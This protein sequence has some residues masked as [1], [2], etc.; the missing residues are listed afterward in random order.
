MLSGSVMP[1]LA[2]LALCSVCMMYLGQWRAQRRLRLVLRVEMSRIFEQIDLLRLDSLQPLAEG[3]GALRSAPSVMT[4]TLDAVSRAAPTPI[5][6]HRT[7]S[8]PT[9]EAYAAALELAARGADQSELT[10]RC[11]L[12]R[13]EARILVAMQGAA[14]RRTNAA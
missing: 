4:T 5:S 1:A 13:D 7:M 10:T 9:G 14:A 3:I 6:F 8:L 11:G 12:G 2:V